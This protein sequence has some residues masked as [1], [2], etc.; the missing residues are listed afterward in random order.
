MENDYLVSVII[1]VHNTAN[2]LRKCV[3]SVINQSLKKIEIILV[4][5]LSTDGSSDICDEYAR[6]DSRI[7]VFHIPVANA[8]IARN[9]GIEYASASYVGFIDSDDYIDSNMYEE[10]F[11]VISSCDADLV[12]SNFLIEYNDGSQMFYEPNTGGVYKRLPKDV[13]YDMV[14][15]RLNSSCCTKLFKKKL[16]D[17]LKFPIDNI[18][19]DRIV[20]H[21]WVLSCR[22]V[23]WVDKTFYHYVE[24]K[25]SICHTISPVNR[26]HFFLAQYF[27][28]KFIGNSLL[29][30]SEELYQ[31][32]LYLVKSCLRTFKE[33]LLFPYNEE[34]GLFIVNMRFHFRN[35]LV[36]SKREIGSSNYKKL[37]KITYFWPLYYW[38]HRPSCFY[39][40]AR[41]CVFRII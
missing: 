15:D 5:N 1:P 35:M 16:F 18:Y 39:V 27:R 31:M 23:V 8:S 7:K 26:Y 22:E 37:R 2:Y 20:L 25:T 41:K 13:V 4:E 38:M 34:I 36:L 12:Y 9:V 28:L 21:Q 11:N 14:C 29:F 10:L 17:S 6:N 24:R 19:E 3:D 33:I 32:R 30:S 40:D